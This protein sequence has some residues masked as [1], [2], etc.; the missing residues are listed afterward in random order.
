MTIEEAF[1]VREAIRNI[2]C[3]NTRNVL[4][5]IVYGEYDKLGE[6]AVVVAKE[7]LAFLKGETK[8][9]TNV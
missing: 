5:A 7:D 1:I 9:S 8:W 4:A 3:R 6:E 2:K